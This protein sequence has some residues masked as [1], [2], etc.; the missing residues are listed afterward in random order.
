MAQSTGAEKLAS[1]IKPL[2]A[3]VQVAQTKVL[4]EFIANVFVEQF[5][6]LNVRFSTIDRNISALDKKLQDYSTDS[7]IRTSHGTQD[8]RND[9]EQ[10]NKAL[11]QLGEQ[12]N[13][14]KTIKLPVDPP[15]IAGL[16]SNVRAK[17]PIP[18][19]NMFNHEFDQ[20]ICD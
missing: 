19:E 4:Q 9:I 2:I 6:Q 1:L 10:L 17:N 18:Q 5:S 8:I 13:Q 11:K 7:K 12:I 3:E 15:Q 14:A 20:T 16:P